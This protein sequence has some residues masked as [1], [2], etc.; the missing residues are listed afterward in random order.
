MWD[1]GCISEAEAAGCGRRDDVILWDEPDGL[2]SSC[3]MEEHWH[4]DVHALPTSYFAFLLAARFTTAGGLCSSELL[5]V[6]NAGD[7]PDFHCRW[8][9]TARVQFREV[10]TNQSWLSV[11]R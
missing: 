1:P 9:A 5:M 8:L 6:Q 2:A 4:Q 3:W 11:E 7:S 10:T